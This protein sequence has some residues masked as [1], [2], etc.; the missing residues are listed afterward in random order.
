MM[1]KATSRHWLTTLVFLFFILTAMDIL[2]QDKP[3][4]KVD[5]SIANRGDEETL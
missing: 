3:Q 1:K 4:M 2:A 5:I